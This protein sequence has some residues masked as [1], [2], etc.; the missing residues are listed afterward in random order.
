MKKIILLTESGADIPLDLVKLHNIQ[1]V[2]MH[3][4]IGG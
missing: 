4:I 1:V 3:V 2:P